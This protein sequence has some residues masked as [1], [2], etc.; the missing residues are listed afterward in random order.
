MVGKIHTARAGNSQINVPLYQMNA[1]M[2]LLSDIVT[3][4]L[5]ESPLGPTETSLR[6]GRF[7]NYCGFRTISSPGTMNRPTRERRLALIAQVVVAQVA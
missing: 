7:K 6:S 4:V 2:G 3:E 1:L 5:I